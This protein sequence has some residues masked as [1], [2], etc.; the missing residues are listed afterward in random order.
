MAA[1]R[2]RVKSL[3]KDI[4]R[5]R[6]NKNEY[7]AVYR[8][9]TGHIRTPKRCLNCGSVFPEHLCGGPDRKE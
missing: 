6:N 2:L 9:R 3:T 1:P 8:F 4:P 7:T 5:N